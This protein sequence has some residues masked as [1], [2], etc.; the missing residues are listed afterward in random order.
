MAAMEG[1]AAEIMWCVKV[2]V[3][4]EAEALAAGMVATVI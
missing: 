1:T 3:K 4:V 2:T